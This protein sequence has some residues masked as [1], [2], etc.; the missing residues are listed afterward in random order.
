MTYQEIIK[1]AIT[2]SGKSLSFI[3]RKCFMEGANISPSYLS[4]LQSGKISPASDK[5][6]CILAKVLNLDTEELLV[7]AYKKKIP[8]AVLKKLSGVS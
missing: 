3:S 8:A 4:K 6:N 1:E 5:I 7:A 2:R